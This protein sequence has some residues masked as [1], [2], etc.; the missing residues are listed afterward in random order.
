MFRIQY[1]VNAPI[2]P[3][4]S[5]LPAWFASDEGQQAHPVVNYTEN[6][7]EALIIS[8][9]VISKYDYGTIPNGN[10]LGTIHLVIEW[11]ELEDNEYDGY[12]PYLHFVWYTE[13]GISQ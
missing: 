1:V 9:A 3:D 13:I 6:I 2:I 4:V 12:A 7:S 10:Y 11:V 5:D 8:A